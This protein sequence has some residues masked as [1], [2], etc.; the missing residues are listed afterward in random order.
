M[1]RWLHR[2]GA[3]VAMAAGLLAGCAALAP[4]PQHIDIGAQAV[5]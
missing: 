4:A 1:V 5:S 3:A 2:C